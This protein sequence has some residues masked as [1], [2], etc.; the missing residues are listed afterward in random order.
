MGG[1]FGLVNVDPR[2][3]GQ[4]TCSAQKCVNDDDKFYECASHNKDGQDK[5]RARAVA[6]VGKCS[7]IHCIGAPEDFKTRTSIISTAADEQMRSRLRDRIAE[8][9]KVYL[10][11]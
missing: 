10:G 2:V 6:A 5:F 4:M 1:L 7:C 8:D 11:C 3:L 9:L